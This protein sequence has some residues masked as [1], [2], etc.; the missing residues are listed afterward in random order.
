[1][2]AIPVECGDKEFELDACKRCQFIWFDRSEF[3]ELPFL[4]PKM[5]PVEPQLPQ[6][7]REQI[8]VEKAKQIGEM[9][10]HEAFP[11][12]GPDCW[13]QSVLGFFGM[14]VELDNPVEIK[15]WA[16]WGL[17][18]AI[19]LVS[20]FAFTEAKDAIGEY[21]LI[22]KDPWRHGGVTLLTSFFL[23]GGIMHLVGNLY[24]FMVF[25][26]NVEEFLGRWRF[27]LLLFLATLAGDAFHIIGDARSSIPCIGA[28]GGISGI[29][30]F[31]ALQFPGARIGFLWR[32]MWHYRWFSI[33]AIAAIAIWGLQQGLGVYLQMN[34]F[35][36]VSSL[37]HIGGA[38]TGLAFWIYYR[39]KAISD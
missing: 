29:I 6:P 18:L 33:P 39:R 7:I 8:A 37:A 20:V 24:F 1:M 11:S 16:T 5:A 36:H 3:H 21:G 15:P 12:D 10:R 23:H 13:W 22:P 31:Y 35:S 25:G 26:D 30:T 2:I 9:A 27:L 34:G 28:S 38:L 19:M 32:W 17:S 4:P 14:P